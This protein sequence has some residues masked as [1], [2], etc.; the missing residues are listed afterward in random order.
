[1]PGYGVETCTSP[2]DLRCWAYSPILSQ[3]LSVNLCRYKFVKRSSYTFKP[4]IL[5]VRFWRSF[6]VSVDTSHNSRER[7]VIFVT[8]LSSS[9]FW[10]SVSLPLDHGW[11]FSWTWHSWY[12]TLLINSVGKVKNNLE[13]I[14]KDSVHIFLLSRR[15]SFCVELHFC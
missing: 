7:I 1:M 11:P 4:L 10:F 15:N 3:R 13:T 9:L 8:R 5:F 6:T 12:C 2:V 14:M